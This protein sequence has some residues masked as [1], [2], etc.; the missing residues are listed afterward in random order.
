MGKRVSIA[1]G[2]RVGCGACIG[3]NVRIGPEVTIGNAA[4]IG[5]G[6]EIRKSA[7]IGPRAVIGD[8]AIISEN[9]RLQDCNIGDH[10]FVEIGV[11]FTGEGDNWITIGGHCYLGIYAVLDGSSG[12]EIGDYVH[13]AGP[14][15]GIW[16]HTSVYECL[17]G[18]SLENRSKKVT[19]RV[20]IE[21]NV[22]VGGNTT[23]YPGVTIGHH[24]VIMPNSAVDKDVASF[25][26]VGGV[27]AKLKRS[28]E[29]G[30]EGV[31]FA[32]TRTGASV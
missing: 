24:A 28:I 10:T 11:I 2:V 1:K 16:T 5:D 15:V 14:S 4:V 8:G 31:R 13:V 9:A 30:S 27:P 17:A 29:M 20:R 32:K 18:D 19:G 12:L 3:Q 21:S 22:W 23:I 6:V 26:M 7:I 25:S